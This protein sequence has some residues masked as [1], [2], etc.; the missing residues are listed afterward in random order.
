MAFAGQLMA[1]GGL[2]LGLQQRRAHSRIAVD[3]PGRRAAARPCRLHVAAIAAPP[4][5]PLSI[6]SVVPQQ[7]YVDEVRRPPPTVSTLPG[8][9]PACC[10]GFIAP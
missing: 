5:P 1:G 10:I 6:P 7:A 8:W 9:P 4:R 3:R 2:G